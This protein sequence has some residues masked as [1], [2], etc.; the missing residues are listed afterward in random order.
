VSAVSR[1]VTELK[2]N[3]PEL[4]NVNVDVITRGL[5]MEYA[6]AIDPYTFKKHA[7]AAEI[8]TPA[9]QSIFIVGDG[10]SDL[11]AELKDDIE[12]TQS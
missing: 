2:N 1:Y 9:L 10:P 7:A 4:A 3:N 8:I 12:A 6:E 11:F 5:G